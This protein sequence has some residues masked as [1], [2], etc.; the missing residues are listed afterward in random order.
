M[1]TNRV[2]RAPATGP[3]LSVQVGVN[4]LHMADRVP[5]VPT[6][7]PCNPYPPWEQS[8]KDTQSKE[9]A[10]CRAFPGRYSKEQPSKPVPEGDRG[11]GGGKR[12]EEY[13][14]QSERCEEKVQRHKNGHQGIHPNRTENKDSN[15]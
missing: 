3:G 11:G 6:H 1:V 13:S 5:C 10:F 8:A 9:P 12:E 4:S 2:Q 7:S 15:R 14:R